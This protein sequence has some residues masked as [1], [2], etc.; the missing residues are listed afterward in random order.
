MVDVSG[1]NNGGDRTTWLSVLSAEK[2]QV[3][4]ALLPSI[5]A[6]MLLR[7]EITYRGIVPLPDSLS[8][9]RFVYELSKRGLKMVEKTEGIWVAC[10]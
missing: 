5:A 7:G 1:K 8:R 10:N 9:E 4:P 6:Q 3:I 2:G